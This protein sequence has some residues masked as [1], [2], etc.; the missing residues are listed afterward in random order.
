M[1]GFASLI[2][3]LG[4][5]A[6]QMNETVHQQRLLD[7]TEWQIR[8]QQL[9]DMLN[10]A[11]STSQSNEYSSDIYKAM[12]QL[13]TI[14]PGDP[15]KKHQQVLDGIQRLIAVHPE[16]V[17]AATPPQ[18][19]KEQLSGP[20]P[21]GQ[22]PGT[23]G[24]ATIGL[25]NMLGGGTLNEKLT[26]SPPAAQPQSSLVSSTTQG[27]GVQ[28]DQSASPPV[29]IPPVPQQS[30]SMQ[31]IPSAQSS[32]GQQVMDS[33]TK[34]MHEGAMPEGL[35]TMAQP[36]MTNAADL[37]Q[38][39]QLEEYAL[40]KIGP[41]RL[42][43]LKQEV[44]DWDNMPASLQA[45]HVESAI[46]MTP[47]NLPMGM[48]RIQTLGTNVPGSSAS[49]GQK[50]VAGNPVDQSP[51]TAYDVKW[52]PYQNSQIWTP[53]NVRN[54]NLPTPGGEGG[55]NPYT[56]KKA[57]DY[58]EAVPPSYNVPRVFT[59]PDSREVFK[60][61]AGAT[62]PT[63]G[64]N[65]ALATTTTTSSTNPTLEGGTITKRESAKTVP[66]V[67]ATPKIPQ[68]GGTPPAGGG[69]ARLGIQS[70]APPTAEDLSPSNLHALQSATQA[71]RNVRPFDPDHAT[72]DRIIRDIAQDAAN[73]KEIPTRGPFDPVNNPSKTYVNA[74]MTQLGLAP[75]NV[76]GSIRDRAAVAATIQPHID[77]IENLLDQAQKDGDMGV[78]M[79]RL[80]R[81]LTGDVGDDPTK[82]KIFSKLYTELTFM[83]SA[84]SMAHGGAR[85]GA[86][87]PLINH[88]AHAI[89]ATDPATL[90]SELG[91][92]REWV[93][94]YAKMAGAQKPV[95]PNIPPVPGA[96]GNGVD[97]LV[98]KYG[99]H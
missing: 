33:I 90:R 35:R 36:Y 63:P 6:R 12:G 88:W 39:Q 60:T 20:T 23:G 10:H 27:G 70:S 97:D 31:P 4:Q 48:S 69:T 8:Q 45:A 85:A 61:A 41:E 95:N 91:A 34:A 5:G 25:G 76:T 52:D 15:W 66:G 28:Q 38:K 89:G 24:N 67:P 55:F 83:N 62:I 81:I 14:R 80:N 19:N 93:D 11:L 26:G 29:T 99:G 9:K 54:V 53:T 71:F 46:G 56:G 13:N 94:G 64:I 17:A 7:L 65:P 49:P 78:V 22:S 59:M 82:G 43:R 47:V 92:V 84:V 86:S 3:G 21:L 98:K 58:V 96:A 2:G 16:V 51:G 18:T 40:H 77:T 44:P 87:L 37:Y 72:V 50:D 75:N 73:E 32:F 79:T 42:A 57:A 74:R 1:G 68:V 30:S